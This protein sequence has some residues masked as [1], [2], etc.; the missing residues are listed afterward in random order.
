[1]EVGSCGRDDQ[2]NAGVHCA[3]GRRARL[4]RL[5]ELSDEYIYTGKTPCF[6]IMPNLVCLR[7]GTTPKQELGS[8]YAAPVLESTFHSV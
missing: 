2:L 3:F 6:V 5:T 1:M 7:R 4:R 8:E